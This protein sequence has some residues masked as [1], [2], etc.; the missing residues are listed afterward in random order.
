MIPPKP[1]VVSV[2]VEVI[3]R[4]MILSEGGWAYWCTM[5]PLWAVMEGSLLLATTIQILAFQPPSDD[6]KRR[7]SLPRNFRDSRL[8]R[9][10][11]TA[12]L[13]SSKCSN[14][15]DQ[16]RQSPE[17]RAS[18]SSPEDGALHDHSGQKA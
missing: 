1:Q 9:S 10:E 3:I 8:G 5:V 4:P 12:S 7:A 2:I 6:L 16:E 15:S 18:G 14:M 13:R 11:G 17:L